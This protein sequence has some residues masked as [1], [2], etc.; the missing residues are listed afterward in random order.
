[1]NS[2]YDEKITISPK[3]TGCRLTVTFNNESVEDI[4]SVI[5]ETLGL[6]LTKSNK[7][8]FL[9]GEGCVE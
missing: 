4:A 9:E 8:Y 2:V 1:V 6:R 7:G 5:A 3:V